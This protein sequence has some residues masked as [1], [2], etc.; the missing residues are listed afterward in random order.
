MWCSGVQL[1]QYVHFKLVELLHHLTTCPLT[2]A[3]VSPGARVT[4]FV[5]VLLT[6]IFKI[7]YM[8]YEF[9]IEYNNYY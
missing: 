3:E 4:E 6:K 2:T 1:T 7:Q 9:E 5:T 8:K